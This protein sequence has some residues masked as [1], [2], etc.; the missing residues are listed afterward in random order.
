MIQIIETS[1]FLH[2]VGLVADPSLTPEKQKQME[3]ERRSQWRKERLK[4][5]ENV[6]HN[7]GF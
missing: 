1:F 7:S 4:S 5:L 2:Q 6:S 3:S